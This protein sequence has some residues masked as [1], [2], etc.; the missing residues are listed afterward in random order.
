MI[1]QTAPAAPSVP[2]AP[3]PQL[4]FD[5]FDR[6]IVVQSSNAPL[7][8]DAGLLPIRQ[9]DERIGFTRQFAAALNDPRDPALI[10]HSMLD[11]VRMRI[12]GI[13]ADYE[14]QNDHDTLRSD[15]VFKLIAN[16]SPDD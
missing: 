2:D 1:L 3:V 7:T 9:F 10:E 6:P 12:Y 11:M 8:S 13:I 14:D 4:C 15:P 16:R 5:F